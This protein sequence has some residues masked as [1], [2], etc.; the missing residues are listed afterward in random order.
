MAILRGSFLKS[1]V[2]GF[3]LQESI[4]FRATNNN[5]CNYRGKNKC[6]EDLLEIKSRNVFHLENLFNLG[7]VSTPYTEHLCLFAQAI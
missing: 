3:G 7:E 2:A 1:S 6:L 4:T 5:E